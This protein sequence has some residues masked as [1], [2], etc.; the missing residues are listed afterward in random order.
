METNIEITEKGK[1]GRKPNTSRSIFICYKVINN[2]FIYQGMGLN[3]THIAN[4][5]DEYSGSVG[6]YLSGQINTLGDYVVVEVLIGEKEFCDSIEVR[7]KSLN[8]AKV[9]YARLR[10]D[11]TVDKIKNLTDEQ[12]AQ[13]TE[14]LNSKP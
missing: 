8:Q 6:K 7:E 10:L 1:R 5:I 3:K 14:I 13:I 9:R 11:L 2:E 4:V 12:V